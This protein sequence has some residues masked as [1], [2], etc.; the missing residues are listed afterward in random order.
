MNP[1]QK[2]EVKDFLK[3][4]LSRLIVQMGFEEKIAEKLVKKY[5]SDHL[6]FVRL[7]R[8]YYRWLIVRACHRILRIHKK[9]RLYK[10]AMEHIEKGKKNLVLFLTHNLLLET[11]AYFSFDSDESWN[12]I[13]ERNPFFDE[14]LKIKMMLK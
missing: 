1:F 3:I 8:K 2:K 14:I 10:K 11:P 12:S 4:C 5:Q 6:F 7:H 13:G 9:I